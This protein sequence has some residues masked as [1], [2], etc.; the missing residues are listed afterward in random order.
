MN[1]RTRQ[2]YLPPALQNH[3]RIDFQEVGTSLTSLA[4]DR[5]SV[6]FLKNKRVAASFSGRLLYAASSQLAISFLRKTSQW[7][8]NQRNV[9]ANRIVPTRLST[10]IL[11]SSVGASS[12]AFQTLL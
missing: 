9:W 7:S 5:S 3:Q 8:D 10:K 2:V 11:Y 4:K 6:W 12:L 1:R